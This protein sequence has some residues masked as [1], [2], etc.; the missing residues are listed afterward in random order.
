M[1]QDVNRA[2]SLCPWK[3]H[4]QVRYGWAVFVVRFWLVHT[5]NRDR[6][7]HRIDTSNP[8][9]AEGRRGRVEYGA[10]GVSRLQRPVTRRQQRGGGVACY[11]QAEPDSEGETGGGRDCNFPCHPKVEKVWVTRKT[12]TPLARRALGAAGLPSRA[13]CLRQVA[14]P[15]SAS[16]CRQRGR[17]ASGCCGLCILS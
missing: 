6:C 3:W 7:V 10:V 5:T 12:D 8:S 2:R 17:C 11:G 14:S 4:K 9:A 13:M 1:F 15:V 16:A